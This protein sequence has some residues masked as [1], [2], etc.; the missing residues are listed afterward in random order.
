MAILEIKDLSIDFHLGKNK[1]LPAVRG[2]SFS[3]E[4]GEVVAL[5][6]ESGSGK[7]ATALSVM[8]LHPKGQCRIQ[9]DV[10]FC[11]E[12]LLQKKEEE[13]RRIRGNQIAMVYQDPMSS[14]NP[15]ISVGEQVA[16]GLMIHRGLSKKE[17]RVQAIA[18]MERVGI[19]EAARRYDYRPAQFSGG[20]RQRIMIAMALICQPKLLIAD[21]PTTALDVTVQAEILTLLKSLIKEYQMAVLLITHDLGVVAQMA[22]RV[23]V[24][25]CGKIME[26]AHTAELFRAPLNPY[27]QGLIRCI[28]R[29]DRPEESLYTIG[30][31]IP[32]PTNLPSG[33]AFRTRCD[34]A[35]PQCGEAIPKLVE[36]R[37]HHMVRCIHYQGGGELKCSS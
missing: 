22:D 32:H 12:S 24:M 6:G 19:P 4:A 13:L 14:L 23:M 17:A 27:T 10:L 20:M 9:G 36:E 33:C 18:M 8:G 21:E 7:S 34:R 29:V 1:V 3:I 37:P 28:P 30:G 26:V 35:V 16:E 25:Y 2:I 11:G 15:L 5:V 31:Y